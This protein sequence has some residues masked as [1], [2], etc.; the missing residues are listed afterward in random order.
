MSPPAPLRAT[1]QGVA[2]DHARIAERRARALVSTALRT[3]SVHAR[4]V[5]AEVAWPGHS[6]VELEQWACAH[7]LSTPLPS[8]VDPVGAGAYGR[9]AA[10]QVGG[11]QDGHIARVLLE[12]AAR[13]REWPEAPRDQ[14][15]VLAQL[16]VLD[17]DAEGALELAADPRVRAAVAASVRTDV[18][19]PALVAPGD[20]VAWA[21]AFGSTLH[22]P[23]L[24]PFL[25]PEAGELPSIDRLRVEAR[26]SVDRPERVTVLMSAYRPGPA[27]LTAVRSV[28]AQ[29]WTNL[30]L[31]VV[32]DAS[33]PD[34]AEVLELAEALDP[35]VRV[36]RKA[37]NG[38]TYRARNTALR[39][40]TGD[41]AVVLDSDDWWHPQTLELCIRPLL[42]RPSLLATRAQ[43]V[44]TSPELVL[45][46][47]GYVPRFTSAATV[48]FRIRPV[49][50]RIGFFDPTR[51]GADTEFA[52]RM[53]A[54]F[55]PV[56]Q[57]IKQTTTIL[58][59]GGETL[60]SAEFSNGWRHPA[61]HQYKS[62][63]G[64]WHARVEQGLSDP[65][66][67]PEQPRRF[68]EPRRW[69]RPVHPLLA[70]A[71]GVDL[72]LAGDWRGFG[73]PQLSM[74]EE[75]R[76]A[77]SAGL[78]VAVMHLEA[79]RFMGNRDLPLCDPV[80]DLVDAGEV[81]WVQPDDDVD[82]AVL[83]VRY[84]P[85]LQYPPLLTRR[86]RVGQVLVMAN[87][88]PLELDG[89]DQRYVV[90]D[91]TART[92][93]LFDAPV[94]WLPQ[95]PTIR[96]VL[97]EQD[98]T[99]P[100]ADWDNPGL[101][102]V[103]QWSVRDPGAP[104]GSSGRVVVGRHSRDN[105]IKFPPTY[106]E[107]LRGYTFPDGYE[108]R[109][110]GAQTTVEELRE[111]EERPAPVPDSWTVLPHRAVDVRDFLAGLD[112]FLYLDNPHAHEAFGR[113]LLEAAASGVLTIAHPKHRP[114][115]GDVV[116]YAEP[117]QAQ[118]LVAH[119]VADPAAYEARVR[120]TRK[121]VVER[122]GHAGF[123]RRL[124]E[125][126]PPQDAPAVAPA[127][128]RTTVRLTLGVG[129]PAEVH[130]A[131]A[132]VEVVVLRSAADAER[133]DRLTVLHHGA[134]APALRAWLRPLLASGGPLRSHD[135]LVATAPP[136]VVAV[137]ASRDGLTYAAGRGRWSGAARDEALCRLAEPARQEGWDD[138]AWWDPAG[139]AHLTLH[140]PVRDEDDQ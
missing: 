52:R 101:I 1:T 39:Q 72:C 61:R 82:I 27:L 43:G 136:A 4:E 2:A 81:E 110:L 86:V 32:D 16:R 53:E 37:V 40:A 20:G 30:E 55:G 97:L 62:A 59:G 90:A 73:G 74:L 65:Y 114:T 49:M 14:V 48:L 126:V 116:D 128:S 130:A 102:D 28:L 10:V 66:L 99:V 36:I 60:S 92:R 57:D 85:I 47:P 9:V 15:E 8:G 64:V 117:G 122:F 95:S 93:E 140:P 34:G 51:K 84:P 119:Y 44:R 77:R 76:A 135:E 113:T 78:R 127:P 120:S 125:L 68:P 17:G 69:E 107:L 98:P 91:V 137:L 38:G 121:A 106:D 131:E 134:S 71:A 35:R 123:V 42:D 105:P 67:D 75:V 46:R 139:P 129:V 23:R 13:T 58:R 132:D 79:L 115:F 54:A 133:T 124:R 94:A 118:Q 96:R 89:G 25:A 56:I 11:R 31:L 63:Y 6:P 70:R 109:M 33:G 26:P 22:G 50:A 24:A 111:A 3:K 5:L 41:V 83:M 108:V 19:N 87:Q 21:A 12:G 18:L 100:L 138:L 80:L 45:T 103:E 88:A 29:T 7:D 104:V 112:F